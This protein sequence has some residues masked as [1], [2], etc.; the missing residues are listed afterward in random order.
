MNDLSSYVDVKEWI[1]V[2]IVNKLIL[3]YFTWFIHDFVNHKYKIH[4]DKRCV[5]NAT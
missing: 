3:M 2:V 4:K 1:L 5:F